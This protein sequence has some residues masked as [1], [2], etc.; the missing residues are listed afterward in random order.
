MLHISC[1]F[2]F[3]I[4]IIW[5]EWHTRISYSIFLSTLLLE[6][7][8]FGVLTRRRKKVP[9][10]G[11]M[12]FNSANIIIALIC[13]K[14]WKNDRNTSSRDALGRH[15][16]WPRPLSHLL[17][18]RDIQ[19]NTSLLSAVYVCIHSSQLYLIQLQLHLKT[20]Q[21]LSFLSFEKYGDSWCFLLSAA[22]HLSRSKA[23]H[24]QAGHCQAQ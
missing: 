19:H 14:L 21:R 17:V 18:F 22:F 23:G 4:I 3:V 24:V 1:L 20:R 7:I 9:Y 11:S 12:G 8:Q 10:Q 16:P 15:S 5:Q 6:N 13:H 2:C